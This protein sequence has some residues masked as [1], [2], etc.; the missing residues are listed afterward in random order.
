MQ[1][2][3]REMGRENVKRG[4]VVAALL[5][6]IATSAIAAFPPYTPDTPIGSAPTSLTNAYGRLQI[7]VCYLVPDPARRVTCLDP[8]GR[9]TIPYSE[10]CAN[11]VALPVPTGSTPQEK[12][13]LPA[14]IDCRHL[15]IVSR[16]YVKALEKVPG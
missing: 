11:L 9:E 5:S 16:C 2:A 1:E 6:A 4:I 8:L 14:V 15:A 10:W 3:S 12:E 13:A 7:E